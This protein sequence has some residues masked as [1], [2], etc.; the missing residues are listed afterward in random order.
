MAEKTKKKYFYD[1]RCT[2]CGVVR[3]TQ[4]KKPRGDRCRPCAGKETYVPPTSERNN[5]RRKGDGYVTKQGYH[6]VFHEGRYVPA[7]TL[8]V[9]PPPGQIVHHVDGNKLNNVPDN[10]HPCTRAAHRDIHHQ[11]ETLSYFLIQ[12]GLTEF[13]D[14]VYEFSCEMK[15]FLGSRE[16]IP[17]GP[18]AVS[19]DGV[20]IPPTMT[21]RIK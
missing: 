19:I 3:R 18:G 21:G 11:L 6:L 1:H 14:G 2:R 7:H 9:A 15:N 5:A 16:T 4:T 12:Q 13:K 10:L 20:K 17:P 8:V